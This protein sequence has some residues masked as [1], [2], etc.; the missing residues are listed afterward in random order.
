[1]PN[2]TF[3]ETSEHMERKNFNPLGFDADRNSINSA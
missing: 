1:M 3:Q 2:Y